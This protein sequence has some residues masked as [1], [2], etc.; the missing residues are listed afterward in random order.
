[1]IKLKISKI[2]LNIII[3]YLKKKFKKK[4]YLNFLIFK[5]FEFQ[6]ILTLNSFLINQ[7]IDYYKK[8]HLIQ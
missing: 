8:N 3:Q 2:I 6:Y 4:V 1:M 5:N 7:D